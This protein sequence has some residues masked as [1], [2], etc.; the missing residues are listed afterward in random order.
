M[1]IRKVSKYSGDTPLVL[2]FRKSA[3]V[4]DWPSGAMVIFTPLPRIKGRDAV[5]TAATPGNCLTRSI[6]ARR[7][8]FACSSE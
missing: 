4:V 8:D 7:S 3:G 1:G 5:A 2:V 6:S